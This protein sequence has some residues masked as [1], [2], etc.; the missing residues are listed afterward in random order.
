MSR[1]CLVPDTAFI[2]CQK[3]LNPE[4]KQLK[5]PIK[6]TA[7]VGPVS[8]FFFVWCF[9]MTKLDVELRIMFFMQGC[10]C[11]VVAPSAA[12]KGEYLRP[13]L[14][15]SHLGCASFTTRAPLLP[16]PAH[17]VLFLVI[18]RREYCSP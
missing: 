11:D 17:T 1:P 14:M 18:R 10:F 7:T 9:Q 15:E 3:R 2:S 5:R 4:V 12:R 16:S 13:F 6:S 8:V